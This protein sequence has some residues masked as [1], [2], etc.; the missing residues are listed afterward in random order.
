MKSS[1]L[2]LVVG[3]FLS[4]GILC[5]A[6]LSIKVAR[7]DFFNTS[8]YEVQAIFSNCSGLKAGSSVMIAGVEIGRVKKISLQ[9]YEARVQM[10]IQDQIA[11][12]KDVIASIKT[13]GLIGEKYVEVTPGGAEEKLR[14][15][16]VIHD[17]EPAMDIEGLIS[18]YVHGNLDKPAPGPAPT[19]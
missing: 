14:P 13:K 17:T 2:E 12:Q 11:L 1:N 8:G 4:L 19:K 15:G 18:K 3:A 5:L 6:Y 16:G 10:M 9:D 7:H